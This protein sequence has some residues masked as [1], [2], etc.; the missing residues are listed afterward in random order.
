MADQRLN[1]ERLCRLFG[2]KTVWI[3]PNK[4][5]QP[6]DQVYIFLG[7]VG[8]EPFVYYDPG[9]AFFFKKEV[10]NICTPQQLSFFCQI[11]HLI[12]N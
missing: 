12:L 5:L 11:V 10:N 7:T 8:K 6:N 4:C 2:Q 9:G 1:G 3:V